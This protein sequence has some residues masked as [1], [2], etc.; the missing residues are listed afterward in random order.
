MVEPPLSNISKVEK[1][2]KCIEKINNSDLSY[3]FCSHFHRFCPL[4]LQFYMK[5]NNAPEIFSD[6][7][8]QPPKMLRKMHFWLWSESRQKFPEKRE[9]F[10][11]RRQQYFLKEFLEVD[12]KF[13][14]NVISIVVLHLKLQPQ[15]TKSL[16]MR[17]KWEQNYIFFQC[18]FP[19]FQFL[20]YLT[21]V[22][23]PKTRSQSFKSARLLGV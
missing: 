10:T 4:W 7:M 18:I 13:Q 14:K 21:K 3:G 9:S 23:L 2:G 19:I 5:Y 17:A 12:Q 16:E 22:A 20:R 15:Q 6:F 8:D 1:W 11:S